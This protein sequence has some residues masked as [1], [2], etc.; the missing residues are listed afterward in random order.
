MGG[1]ITVGRYLDKTTDSV[2]AF[3]GTLPWVVRQTDGLLPLV[4]DAIVLA[5]DA[6]NRI[7]T[8]TYKT[9]GAGGATVATLTLTYVGT[10]R[11]I[12]SAVR[13]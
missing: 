13:T 10:S 6:S 3:Q 4:F 9:G 2:T 7:S 8:A 5:Y 12:A 1:K 11:R